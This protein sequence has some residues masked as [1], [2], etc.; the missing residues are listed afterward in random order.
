MVR[1]VRIQ[2]WFVPCGLGWW[3]VIINGLHS[4]VVS[5]LTRMWEY[6]CA[7][8]SI[9]LWC[10]GVEHG[11]GGR[12]LSWRSCG[13][14]LMDR[15]GWRTNVRSWPM[16]RSGWVTSRGGWHL[17]HAVAR[18]CGRAVCVV[19]AIEY[20]R[21]TCL[22]HGD[23]HVVRYSQRFGGWS[24]KPAALRTVGFRLRLASKPGGG[25]SSGNYR[26]YMVWSRWC[27]K[28]NKLRVKSV[29]IG[30]NSRSWS[31]SPPVEWIGYM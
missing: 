25:N 18:V 17:G 12:R 9:D 6:A 10:G 5:G 4:R 2:G 29:V 22:G 31:I 8:M 13:L 1:V 28:A 21:D 24:S 7:T 19:G 16:D 11:D 27:I 30:E 20:W 3:L 23:T 26:R 15:E 14:L